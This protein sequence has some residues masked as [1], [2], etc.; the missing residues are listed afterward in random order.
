VIDLTS[1]T[2]CGQLEISGPETKEAVFK[3]FTAECKQYRWRNDHGVYVIEPKEIR[4]S[5]L[6][7][8]VGPL[9]G[10]GMD[11]GDVISSFLKTAKLP[12]RIYLQGGVTPGPL[13]FRVPLLK[14]RVSFKRASLRKNL[15]NAAHQFDASIWEIYRTPEDTFMYVVDSIDA[16][17]GIQHQRH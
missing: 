4:D 10:N 6:G 11:A 2:P 1:R 8:I 7:A 17:G 16:Q 15:V 14:K 3:A 12:L 9:E 13:E 5:A